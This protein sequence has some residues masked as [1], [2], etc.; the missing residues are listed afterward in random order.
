[1]LTYRR[2]HSIAIRC[3]ACPEIGANIDKETIE[4]ATEDEA[5]VPTSYLRNFQLTWPTSS[6]KFTLFISADGNFCL[7]RK[8]KKGDPDDVALNEGNGYCV[9][10]GP[11]KAYLRAIHG[12]D[13][14]TVCTSLRPVQVTMCAKFSQ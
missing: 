13:C 2:P 6:H 4:F 5:C 12:G 11:Y 8:N 14:D 3:P 9:D 7:Q 10:V 1:V